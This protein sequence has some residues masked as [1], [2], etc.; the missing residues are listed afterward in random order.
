MNLN[1]FL[2]TGDFYE[3]FKYSDVLK[4]YLDNRKDGV[5]IILKLICFR[6]EQ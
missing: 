4:K 3:R 1:K 2:Y 6:P 5:H